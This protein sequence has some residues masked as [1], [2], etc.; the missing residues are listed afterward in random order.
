MAGVAV[1]ARVLIFGVDFVH[2]IN[3]NW[4]RHVHFHPL[5]LRRVVMERIEARGGARLSVIGGVG[6]EVRGAGL[7]KRMAAAS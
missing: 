3:S 7:P 5:P 2:M 4:Q 1:H 6:S